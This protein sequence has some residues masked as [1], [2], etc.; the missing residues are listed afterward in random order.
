M[1]IF[2][3]ISWQEQVIFIEIMMMSTLYSRPTHRVG[4]L[5]LLAHWNNSLLIEHVA[6]LEHIILIPC[7]PVSALTP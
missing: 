4:L 6:L 3:G 7:Q 2:V 1:P 5:M